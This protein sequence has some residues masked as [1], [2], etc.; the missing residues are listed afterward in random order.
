MKLTVERRCSQREPKY[1]TDRR[2]LEDSHV[3]EFAIVLEYGLEFH[4]TGSIE[5]S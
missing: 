4:S 1:Q 3:Q 2:L 5:E